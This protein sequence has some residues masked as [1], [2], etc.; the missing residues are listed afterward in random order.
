MVIDFAWC[1][2]G[3]GLGAGDRWLEGLRNGWA[4][5]LD[6]ICKPFQGVAPNSYSVFVFADSYDALRCVAVR[7]LVCTNRTVRC[8]SVKTGLNRTA[9]YPHRRKI[10]DSKDPRPSHVFVFV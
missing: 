10:L 6:T 9:P 1:L 5:R 2:I 7:V 8:G 3:G 4:T